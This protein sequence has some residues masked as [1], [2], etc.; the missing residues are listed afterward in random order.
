MTI[1]EKIL[2]RESG[3]RVFDPAKIVILPDHYIFTADAK[4]HRNIDMFVHENRKLFAAHPEFLEGI[5]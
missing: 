2:A 5:K 4:A 1:T 3:A